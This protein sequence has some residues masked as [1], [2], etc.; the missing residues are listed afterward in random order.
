MTLISQAKNDILLPENDFEIQKDDKLLICGDQESM[1]L[2]CWT[3]TNI[4]VY[5]YIQTGYELPGGF[6][7]QWLND[8]KR[9][10]KTICRQNEAG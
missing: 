6:F 3:V 4:N 8:Q 9:L 2:M 7:W 5:N 1:N 10:W